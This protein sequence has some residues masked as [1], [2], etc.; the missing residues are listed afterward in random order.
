MKNILYEILAKPDLAKIS[1][2]TG[3]AAESLFLIFK[4]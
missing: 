3:L 2:K 1:E 4:R